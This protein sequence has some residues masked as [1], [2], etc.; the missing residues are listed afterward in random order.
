MNRTFAFPL[1]LALAALGGCDGAPPADLAA[2]D[3]ATADHRYHAARRDLLAIRKAEG[4]DPATARRLAQLAL[5]LGEGL[6]A[7]RYLDELRSSTG[8]DADWITMRAH[9]LILQGQPR[10]AADWIAGFDGLPPA[11]GAH[12]WLQVWAAMEEGQR[13]VAQELVTKALITYPQSADLH[14]KAGRLMAWQGDWDAVDAHVTAALQA[15]PDHYEALLLQGESRIAR[16]DL[17]G[18]IVPYRTAAKAYPDFAVPSANVAGLLL[19]LGR[20]DEAEQVL[21][22]A[23]ASHPEFPLLRFTSARLDALRKRWP[24]A[25]ATL[26][27][28]PSQ[29]KRDFAPATLLEGE[30]EAA[31]GNYGM[32]RV[33]YTSVASQPQMRDQANAMLAA[34]P[35]A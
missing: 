6:T 20:L 10:R 33:L 21:F 17:N 5:A 4:P 30:A 16:G 24:A 25:L 34:L 23:I 35:P 3:Q 1:L 14:A 11:N 8:E 12:A 2:I 22:P 9:S 27:G 15:A 18:A 13:D 26:R 28:I 19:D 29:F 31:L 7:E 32:A